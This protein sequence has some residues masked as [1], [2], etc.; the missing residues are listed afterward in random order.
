LYDGRLDISPEARE[1]NYYFLKMAEI[2]RWAKKKHPHLIFVIENPDAKLKHMPLMKE[3]CEEFNVHPTT[4]DYCA[5]NRDEKKP[6]SLFTN[7]HH[8]RANLS[9][10]RCSERCPIGKAGGGR[11]LVD[12]RSSGHEYD[13]RYMR[14]LNSW[15]FRRALTR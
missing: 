1:H 13:F 3:F 11:H 5:F 10:Y 12:V 14:M 9:M 15:S 6:T 2:I 8:L 7:D 4:V